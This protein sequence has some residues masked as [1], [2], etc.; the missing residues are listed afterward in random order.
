MVERGYEGE[1]APFYDALRVLAESDGTEFYVG[2]AQR[3][4]GS[5]LEIAC[6]TGRIYLDLLANGVDADGFDAS[7]G[8]LARLREK[9]TDRGLEPSVWQADM[10]HFEGDRVYELVICPFN[11]VQHL[12]TVEDQLGALQSV[13]DALAPGGAF[14]FDVFVPGFE[15]ICEEYDEWSTTEVDYR[16]DW[17]GPRLDPTLL[18]EG[19][20]VLGLRPV[21]FRYRAPWGDPAVPHVGLIAEEV[22]PI[23]PEAVALDGGEE[24]FGIRCGTLDRILV[25]EVGARVGAAVAAAVSRL[26]EALEGG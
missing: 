9:A 6:G 11:T 26:A 23:F 4:E 10:A 1:H 24:T 14:V 19:T 25:E 13:Y 12:L 17:M 15:V 21:A 7:A 16:G 20:T 22:A 18:P 3:V 2:R 5:V 8:A